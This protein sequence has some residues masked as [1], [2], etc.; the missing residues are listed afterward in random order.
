MGYRKQLNYKD[1]REQE[2]VFLSVPAESDSGKCLTFQIAPDV[3]DLLQFGERDE[4]LPFCFVVVP[5][6]A[7]LLALDVDPSI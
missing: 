5:L 1:V 2:D 3:F 6:I 4:I 7:G